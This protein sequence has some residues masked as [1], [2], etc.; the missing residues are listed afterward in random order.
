MAEI[1]NGQ[2][3]TAA[4][5]VPAPYG[6]VTRVGDAP[7]ADPNQNMKIEFESA[8]GV[9]FYASYEELT[10]STTINNILERA[11]SRRGFNHPAWELAQTI[12]ILAAYIDSLDGPPYSDDEYQM[13][14]DVLRTQRPIMA[15]PPNLNFSS[16]ASIV[17]VANF[18]VVDA[19]GA[20]AGL[21]AD[22]TNTSTGTIYLYLWDW[23]DGDT[24]TGASPANHTYAT[25]G[26]KSITLTVVG[27]GGTSSVTKTVDMVTV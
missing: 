15:Q 8:L 11:H 20:G 4:A 25:D 5:A 7:N 18:T 6:P 14:I 17:P 22:V 23:G 3:E 16:D 1:N 13:I 27:P 21:A 9:T 24:S 10:D 26:E 2:I 12:Q 19:D